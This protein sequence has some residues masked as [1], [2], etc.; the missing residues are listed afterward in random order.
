[1]SPGTLS[2]LGGIDAAY[3]AMRARKRG[4]AD[5]V[6]VCDEEEAD[7]G[8]ADDTEVGNDAVFGTNSV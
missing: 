1:M 3:E 2:E 5:K 7:L 8:D 6:Q 4:D